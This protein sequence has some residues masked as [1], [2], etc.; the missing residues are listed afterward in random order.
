[1]RIFKHLSQVLFITVLTFGLFGCGSDKNTLNTDHSKWSIGDI[2]FIRE[3]ITPMELKVANSALNSYRLSDQF[4]FFAAD[5]NAKSTTLSVRTSCIYNFK[6]LP[7]HSYSEPLKSTYSY[8][9]FLP[10]EAIY[11]SYAT[12]ENPLRCAVKLLF[13]STSGSTHSLQLN[14]LPVEIDYNDNYLV[15]NKSNLELKRDGENLFEVMATEM[16]LY[17]LPALSSNSQNYHL[18]CPDFSGQL[19]YLPGTMRFDQFGVKAQARPISICRIFAV[20]KN[21]KV[22]NIS[23]LFVFKQVAQVPSI[24]ILKTA[25]N[26]HSFVYREYLELGHYLISNPSDKPMI[27]NIARNKKVQFIVVMTAA[28]NKYT[29]SVIERGIIVTAK[30]IQTQIVDENVRFTLAPT[31]STSISIHAEA[32]MYMCGR[33]PATGAYYRTLDPD[34]IYIETI[35]DITK[36][37]STQNTISKTL[38]VPGDL[39]YGYLLAR[40]GRYDKPVPV[41]PQPTQPPKIDT[42]DANCSVQ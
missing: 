17:T 26:L 15:L 28:G 7:A 12:P 14:S 25:Q 5:T 9:E 4:R 2:E 11:N 13:T 8:F 27:I 23:D 36:R 18:E 41:T 22:E 38:L 40:S 37:A 19:N 34:G 16:P 3:D 32:T 24:T 21:S 31:Q 39:H 29:G 35:S 42:Y 10:K 20:N 1:M 33:Q 30:D 6:E